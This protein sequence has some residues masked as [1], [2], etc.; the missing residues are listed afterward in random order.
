MSR[1][2]HIRRITESVGGKEYTFRSK[3]ECRWAVWCELRKQQGYITDW[4]YEDPDTLLELKTSYFGNKKRYLPDF[5]IL[6]PNGDYEYEE[7]K[8]YFP[9]KDATKIKLAAEQYENPITLIFANLKNTK[10]SRLQFNRAK[11]LEPFLK[12]IIWRADR[13]I[14]RKIT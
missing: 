10:S 1:F 3:L 13:D 8:G 5:T 14:L 2:N 12:R 4:W 7:I 9:A 11:R 6:Y